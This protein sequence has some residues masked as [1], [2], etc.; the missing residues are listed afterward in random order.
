MRKSLGTLNLTALHTINAQY[1]FIA[2]NKSGGLD[3][4]AETG[5]VCPEVAWGLWLAQAL[6]VTQLFTH[7]LPSTL[8]F[9]FH[10]SRMTMSY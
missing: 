4:T 8:G 9:L 1:A 6:K 7:C 10:A 3:C 5:R 2:N